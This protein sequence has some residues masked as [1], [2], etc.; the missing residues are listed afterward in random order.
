LEQRVMAHRVEGCRQVQADEN[1]HLLVIGCRVYTVQDFQQ[2]SLSR[3]LLPVCRLELAEI[4]G[5]K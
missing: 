4:P 3:M 1:G 5:T 2:C